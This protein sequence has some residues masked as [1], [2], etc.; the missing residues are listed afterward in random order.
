MRIEDILLLEKKVDEVTNWRHRP[1]DVYV[2]DGLALLSKVRA[3]GRDLKAAIKESVDLIGGFRKSLSPGDR[4]LIKPNFNS[5]DPPPA[6]TDMAFVAAVVELLQEEGITDLTVGDRAGWAAMPTAGVIEKLGVL[7]TAKEMGFRFIS[8]EDGPWMDVRLGEK[9]RWWNGRV[10]LIRPLKKFDKIV[11][12][13]VMKTHYATG[14]SMSLKMSVGMMHPALIPY[15]HADRVSGKT[16]EPVYQKMLEIATVVGPDLII[17]DGRKAFVT[18]GPR[19]GDVEEPGV[20]I[21]S[22]DRIAMDVEGA[23]VI[24]QYPRE[25]NPLKLPVWEMPIISHA[26]ELSLGVASEF[27]YRVVTA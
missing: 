14:L 6:S 21:A 5:A 15:L 8:F 22:G 20:I 1:E 19:S 11:Y 18:G 13:P 24:Q 7:R 25:G 4:V 23:R 10:T 16:D 27:E 26:V 17:T 9:T 2:Q 3:E 12:L